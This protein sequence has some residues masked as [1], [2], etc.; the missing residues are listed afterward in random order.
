MIADALRDVTK[1]GAVVLDTFLGSG[2]T[3][4]AAEETGRRCF[5]VELDP[6]YVDLAIR[7][8]QAKTA[9]D[10]AHADTGEFFEDRAPNVATAAEE[11]HHGR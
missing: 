6:L 4:L 10:A 9:R 5:G 11:T 1:R 3:L 8:W 7:R 2:S